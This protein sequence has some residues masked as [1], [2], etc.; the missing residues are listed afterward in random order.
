MGWRF[1]RSVKILPG[2][3][4]NSGKKGFTSATIG[5]KFAK[6]NVSKRSTFNTYSLPG[7]GISSRTELTRGQNNY[8]AAT[9]PPVP[10][11]RYC[12]SCY[13]MNLPDSQFCSSCDGIFPPHPRSLPRTSNGAKVDLGVMGGIFGFFMLC[14]ILSSIGSSSRQSQTGS[15]DYQKSASSSGS[16]QLVATATQ[17]TPKAAL[18]ATT[19]PKTTTTNTATVISENADLRKTS[20]QNCEV[21]EEPR[22]QL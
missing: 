16:S 15:I 9:T 1:R 7:T 17:T 2:V 21:V 18:K 10:L 8:S 5:G 20:D 13:K 4:L 11:N 14:G 12:Q 6:T 22:A 19:A 3:K